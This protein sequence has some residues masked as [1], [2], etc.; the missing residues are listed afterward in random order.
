M[1]TFPSLMWKAGLVSNFVYD[2]LHTHH[3]HILCTHFVYHSLSYTAA[4]RWGTPVLH[5]WMYVV[6]LIEKA[7]SNCQSS[8]DNILGGDE[9]FTKENWDKALALY[10]GSEPRES[11]SGGFFLHTLTQVECYKFG[12]CKKG[13]MSPVNTK[14]VEKFS[15]GKQYLKEGNCS[16]VKEI[17]GD[18]KSLM[19]ILLVQGVSRAMYALD[20]QDDFQET[21]QGMATAFAAAVLPLVDACSQG[22]ATLIHR[23][24]S[25]GK[26]TKGSS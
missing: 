21:T 2:I 25:P 14:I 24:S 5:V 16:H 20:V 7:A 23:D 15:S 3:M 9:M 13:E 11:G 19:T 1:L 8:G 4:I 10:I 18:I 6:G 22:S 17:A 12:T 26:S